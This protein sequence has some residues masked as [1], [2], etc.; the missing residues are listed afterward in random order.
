MLCA[1]HTITKCHLTMATAASVPAPTGKTSANMA[2]APEMSAVANGTPA[3]S[4]A[5]TEIAIVAPMRPTAIAAK[6]GDVGSV[7]VK[8]SWTIVAGPIVTGTDGAETA[9]QRYQ[10]NAAEKKAEKPN[11]ET[12]FV[13]WSGR[14]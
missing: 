14:R 13:H 12:E 10:K 11:A 1:F 5:A 9:S 4:T 3:L 8:V 6:D 2:A 7:I